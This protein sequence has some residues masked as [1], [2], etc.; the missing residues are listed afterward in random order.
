[1]SSTCKEKTLREINIYW[2]KDASGN[3]A[4]PQE[5]GTNLC[6]NDCNG[7][8]ICLNATCICS[9]SF[10]TADCSIK[11]GKDYKKSPKK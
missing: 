11:K 10:I 8:G 4:P 3:L 2:K 1:M 7:N 6:S 5:I 9:S